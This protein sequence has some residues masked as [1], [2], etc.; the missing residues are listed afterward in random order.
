MADDSYINFN[1]PH[2]GVAVEYLE[3]TA[4]TAQPCPHCSEDVIVP[5]AGQQEG[6]A[7][8]LPLQTPRLVLRRLE[9]EDAGELLELMSDPELF[10][11]EPRPAWE[12]A[13]VERWLPK[14][15][16]A[17]LSDDEG[18]MSIALVHER[19]K[20]LIGLLQMAYPSTTRDQ[21]KLE[22]QIHRDYHRQGLATEALL[23]GL[24]FCFRDIRLHRVMAGTDSRN[25]AGTRLLTKVGMRKEA[26]FLKNR[27]I[28]GEWA[29]SV[30]FAML[31]EEFLQ[32]LSKA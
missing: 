32:N 29:N 16:K 10:R 24:N 17:K 18:Q 23:V 25:I 15:V 12:E 2:C 20:K 26:E 6:R 31:R 30:W 11:Y 5:E 21:A 19:D 1:C 28:D 8:P 22:I 14:A 7:L 3:D 13:D 9:L 4:G 27:F